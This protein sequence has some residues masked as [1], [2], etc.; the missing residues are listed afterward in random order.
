MARQERLI[1]DD[2]VAAARL[3]AR[4]FL[5]TMPVA[6]T[7][8]LALGALA[9]VAHAQDV[10]C[11]NPMAQQEMNFCAVQDFNASDAE[12]NEIYPQARAQMREIDSALPDDLKGAEEAL[13][14]AQRAWIAYRDLACEAEGYSF[15][16]GSMELLIVATCKDDLTRRRTQ[17]LK[18]LFEMER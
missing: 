17:D 15:R 3:W 4:A 13:L 5:A 7:A 8:A 1:H 12:L 10:N 11:D 18:S 2:P 9:G 16:G 6:L 14:Q